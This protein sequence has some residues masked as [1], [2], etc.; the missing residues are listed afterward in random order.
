MFPLQ[1]LSS[2]IYSYE[3]LRMIRGNDEMGRNAKFIQLVLSLTNYPFD[4]ECLTLIYLVSCRS[5]MSDT[6]I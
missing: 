4:D 3:S 1:F 2:P 6:R 5:Y